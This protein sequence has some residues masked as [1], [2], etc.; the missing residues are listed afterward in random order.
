MDKKKTWEKIN[1]IRDYIEKASKKPRVDCSGCYE[2][3]V[4]GV[5]MCEEEKEV[6]ELFPE[7][8]GKGKE[9]CRYLDKEGKCS[10]YDERPIMCRAFG[11]VR[12]EY[13]CERNKNN[14]YPINEGLLDFL[15]GDIGT[16]IKDWEKMRKESIDLFKDEP[17][18]LKNIL[19]SLYEAEKQAKEKSI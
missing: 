5:M 19:K 15:H 4:D 6:L 9:M 13:N 14:Y 11:V 10:A 2:C 3:C 1:K 12:M 18:K 17:E 8:W 16:H 7:L